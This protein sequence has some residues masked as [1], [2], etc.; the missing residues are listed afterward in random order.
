MAAAGAAADIGR[1]VLPAKRPM[2]AFPPLVTVPPP[3][4]FS[5][6]LPTEPTSRVL[7]LVQAAAPVPPPTVAVA[8]P[9]KTSAIAAE[10][11]VADAAAAG[12][13]QLAFD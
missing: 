11:G 13:G 4:I 9:L 10:A 8:S 6:P 1:A 7:E 3:V 2:A 5:V 12:D